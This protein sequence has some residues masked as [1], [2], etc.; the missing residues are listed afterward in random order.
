MDP[1]TTPPP[2]LHFWQAF[3]PPPLPLPHTHTSPSP[4]PHKMERTIIF[5]DIF[6]S[7]SKVRESRV[8]THK[9]KFCC[10]CLCDRWQ[11]CVWLPW[12]YPTINELLINFR[13]SSDAEILLISTDSALQIG[14]KRAKACMQCV[15][16][17]SELPFCMPSLVVGYHLKKG[18]LFSIKCFLL[19]AVQNAFFFF[20]ENS[21]FFVFFF[22]FLVLRFPQ[23]HFIISFPASSREEEEDRTHKNQKADSWAQDLA[24][25]LSALVYFNV[26]S[27]QHIRRRRTCSH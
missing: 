1:H 9:E 12:F 17:S 22:L 19:R 26:K 7:S 2:S 16:I 8:Y 21:L 14:A 23:H 4:S 27:R 18:F 24:Y 6:F 15:Y 11:Q 5:L 13:L 20:E 25:L 3:F 10:C